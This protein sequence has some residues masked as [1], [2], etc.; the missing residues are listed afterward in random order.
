MLKLIKRSTSYIVRLLTE[1]ISIATSKER[2]WQLLHTR[3]YSNALYLMTA[4][5]VNAILGFVFWII[6]ARF[7]STEDIGFASAVIAAVG[8][9][10]AFSHLGMGVSLVRFLSHSSNNANSMIN[11]ALTIGILTSS[12]AALI[13]VTGLHFW[14]QSLLFIRQNPLYLAAFVLIA[15]IANVSYLTDQA[16]VAGR[17]AGFVTARYLIFSI[18][19]LALPIPLAAFFKS[20]GIFASWGVSLGIA[21]L[22]SVFLFLPRVHPGYQPF[23][24]ISKKVVND[25]MRFSSAAYLYRLLW[26]MPAWILPIVVLNLLGAESNAYFYIAWTI[27]SAAGMIPSAVSTSLFAEGSHDEVKLG[28]NM[29]RSLKMT[30][31]ILVPAV[32]LIL[33]IADKLLLLFGGTFTENA[34]ILLRVL[35][36]ATLPLT[37]NV[38]FLSTKMVQKELKVVIGLAAYI[39]VASLGL[40]YLLLPQMGITG[41]GIAW[42]FTHGTAAIVV[43]AISLKRRRAVKHIAADISRAKGD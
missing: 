9:V 2:L 38:I 39:V 19:K 20:F 43:V 31:L 34:T 1:I 23:P 29:W 40:T 7:Y 24:T 30:N 4:N 11:T 5:V 26:G 28:L 22:F 12:T 15:I 3:L 35:V 25:I 37:I 8:L 6:V 21:L 42:L 18:L 36:I 17:R 14:S 41:A 16:F 33:A 10:I 27:A 13:F 32:I